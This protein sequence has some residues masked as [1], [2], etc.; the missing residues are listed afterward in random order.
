[1]VV[2]DLQVDYA[3]KRG[4]EMIVDLR[5]GITRGQLDDIEV[6][7]LQGQRVPKL[8]PVEWIDIDGKLTFRYPLGGKRMLAHRL[9][10]QHL[11]MFQFYT[12]L[13]SVVEVIDE[14]KHYML[15]PENFLL[16]E[17]YIFVGE[18]WDDASLAYVP[19]RERRMTASAGEAVLA[20]AIRWVGAIEEPDGIGLQ[21]VFRH[22]RG[23]VVSWA[24]LRQTLL[25]LIGASY[26]QE[27]GEEAKAMHRGER[28]GGAGDGSA[29]NGAR[30][31]RPSNR[32]T[33]GGAT[34]TPESS[35]RASKNP[36]SVERNALDAGNQ[37]RFENEAQRRNAVDNAAEMSR[38]AAN[39]VIFTAFPDAGVSDELPLTEL[40]L[41]A[42]KGTDS[43]SGQ[44]SRMGW[45]I[46]GGWVLA[47]AVVWRF[48]YLDSPSRTNLL[49]SGGLTLLTGAA[50]LMLRRRIGNV[51]KS[52]EGSAGNQG[53][54]QEDAFIPNS[55]QLG[56]K[57]YGQAPQATE[58]S[59]TIRNGQPQHDSGF[60]PVAAEPRI[61]QNHSAASEVTGLLGQT[62]KESV[63]GTDS[64]L[65]WLE[66][67][68]SGQRERIGLE[69]APFIIGRAAEGVQFID[70]ASG[71]SRAHLEL[72]GEEG[73]WT[74]VDMGSRN[75]STLNGSAM[76]PY[77]AY[78]LTNE[79][80]LQLAGE[81]G[82]VY[83][84]RAG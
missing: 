44:P 75:G 43:D 59:G 4:H 30:D 41:S 31:I 60:S 78:P 81:Q 66:R 32:I 11:T 19:L 84:F 58:M 34:A 29:E 71:I 16:D 73:R 40:P 17:H 64:R 6:Q 47:V 18:N 77:K 67:Q 37:E 33:V 72:S 21:K 51:D 1:M 39:K 9:Q 48:L 38:P 55:V 15:R 12:L 76:I 23:S 13:M 79:D 52:Y 35:A 5:D 80:Q 7:M 83:V 54:G 28:N 53:W 49:L 22:L 45:V 25:A 74:A 57:S 2:E 3:M 56:L 14:S 24:L 46:G 63:P 10:T 65:P 62:P 70:S 82:P 50:A 27:A 68:S 26:R 69:Q 8:L 42:Y 20:M 36:V 61:M